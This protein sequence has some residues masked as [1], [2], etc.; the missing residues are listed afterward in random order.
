M[1]PFGFSDH[2]LIGCIRKKNHRK[3]LPKEIKCR[4]YSH[5][6]HGEM[7]RELAKADWSNIYSTNNVNTSYNAFYQIV[8]KIF[9]KY[10]PFITKRI[11]SKPAPWLTAD[12]KAVM[13]DRDKLLRR[14][15]KTKSDFDKREFQNK[16]NK[17][18]ILLRKSKANYNKQLLN[19]N[20]ND[21]DKFWTTLKSIYPVSSKESQ[22]TQS[23]EINDEKTS[24]EKK[25]ANGFKSFFSS[26]VNVL[27]SKATIMKDYTWSKPTVLNTRTYKTFRFNKVTTAD[28]CDHLKKLQRKKATG[29]DDLPSTFLIDSRNYISS[30]LCH[31]INLSMQNG[32]VPTEWKTA[33]IVPIYKS[34][35]KTAF[36]N[37]RPIS[38]LP[39]ISKV[40]EKIVHRQ[41]ITFL[42]ENKLLNS[43]Q[44]G[45]RNKMSTEHA[46]TIFIDSIRKKVDQGN[47]VGACFIDL[48]K[49]F[50]TISH[51]K[52]LAKLPSYGIHDRE[53]SWFT[54]Y[55]F[56]RKAYV[57]YNQTVSDSFL[58]NSGVP[59]G[60]ILGP[61]LF[62][63]IFNDLTDVIQHSQVVKYADDTVLYV[64]AKSGKET[65]KLL[66]KDLSS[67]CDWFKENELFMN[68][69]KGKTETMLFGTSKN[70]SKHLDEFEIYVNGTKINSTK[71]YK[72]LGVPIDSSLNMNS[73]FDACYKKASTRLSLLAKLRYMLNAKAAK[74]IYHSMILPTFTYCGL[75]LLQLTPTQENKLVSFHKRAE[76]IINVK[77]VRSIINANKKHACIF[78]K[79]C[80]EGEVI[81]PFKNYFKLS[82]HDRNTRNNSKL[83]ILPPIK[84]EYARKGFYFTGAKIFNLPPLEARILERSKFVD[85]HFK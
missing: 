59:Q 19:E 42:E 12:I 14:Y 83:I 15:R 28:V 44:F 65:A 63:I 58:F 45:F 84:R 40:I 43:H 6:N 38:I 29:F 23:F 46:V 30:P 51:S 10:A 1:F 75:H 35:P 85:K 37:Y 47:V 72:Y 36:D 67:A 70:V 81:D 64:H 80:L 9:D 21:P 78:V 26:I 62:L 41:L 31:I 2:E 68:Y 56:G 71:Q 5:Y 52:L 60:S 18:N 39:I 27:K 73:F 49:A 25:I 82:T 77:N 24:N 22:R 66:T 3:Y 8:R 69:R 20:S 32:V 53:L 79:S 50:D 17:V 76:R 7:N 11:K 55:L 57:Q 34:G 74:S 4:D 54:D 16:R 48:S 33:R 61:L 13:N